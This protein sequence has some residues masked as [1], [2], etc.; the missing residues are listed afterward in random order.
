MHKSHR[1]GL[2]AW[3]T[4]Y[5]NLLADEGVDDGH[6]DLAEFGRHLT[7]QTPIDGHG[8]CL[9]TGLHVQRIGEGDDLH[10]LGAGVSQ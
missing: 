6:E 3:K 4:I 5:L 2:A 8:R 10:Q 7:G 1:G 9:Q